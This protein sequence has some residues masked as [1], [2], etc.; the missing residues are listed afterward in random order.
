MES[1]ES[2]GISLGGFVIVPVILELRI[3][4]NIEDEAAV[5][6]TG[7]VNGAGRISECRLQVIDQDYTMDRGL[8]NTV[9]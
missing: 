6:A 3:E 1:V 7:K 2:S 4:G 5:F 8:L 9:E